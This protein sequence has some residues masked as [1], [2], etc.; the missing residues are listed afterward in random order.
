[1]S[2]TPPAATPSDA[3]ADPLKGK[4]R[5]TPTRAAQ[6]AAN[7]RPLV[8]D[9]KEAKQRARAELNAQRERARAGMAAGEERYLPARDKGPQ[10]KFVRDWVDS[11][12]SLSEFVMPLM[13]VVIVASFI[14]SSV[15]VFWSFVAL[16]G[17]IL[18][19]IIEMVIT[20]TRVKKA[21]REQWG[22]RTE[23]GLGW[24]AAMR[25][26]QMRFLRI[27]KPQL[28]RGGAPVTPKR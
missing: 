24:Y 6:E 18:L 2:K 25:Q 22:D 27:P 20:S 21:T 23:K 28:R 15:M 13:L 12:W 11:R 17:F 5:P 4:G 9:T 14:P 3:D 26:V 1:M 7:R 10:R 8:A 19:V 16:W